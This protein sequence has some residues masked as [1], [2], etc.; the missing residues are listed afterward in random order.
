MLT[1]FHVAWI[2]FVWALVHHITMEWLTAWCV[3]SSLRWR[4]YPQQPLTIVVLGRIHTLT[5]VSNVSAERSAK[6]SRQGFPIP[7]W[8]QQRPTLSRATFRNYTFAS[9]SSS[10]LFPQFCHAPLPNHHKK[11]CKE[12]LKMK[13]DIVLRQK[14][15]QSATVWWSTQGSTWHCSQ[16]MVSYCEHECWQ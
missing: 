15:D 14:C 9:W 2:I 12:Q 13:F 16:R 5:M 4:T 7:A 8:H 11:S 6:S 10:Q 3:S 1:C